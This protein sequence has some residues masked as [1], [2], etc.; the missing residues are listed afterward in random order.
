MR[1][2]DQRLCLVIWLM[3][4]CIVAFSQNKFINEIFK[5]VPSG[6]D[7]KSGTN[8]LFYFKPENGHVYNHIRLELMNNNLDRTE[9]YIRLTY[10]D[11]VYSFNYFIKP[12]TAFMTI[13]AV[14]DSSSTKRRI[15]YEPIVIHDDKG[16]PSFASTA[17]LLSFYFVEQQNVDTVYKKVSKIYPNNMTLLQVKWIA[18]QLQG[19]TSTIKQELIQLEKTKS[20]D[21]KFYLT[22]AYG[23]FATNNVKKGAL[24]FEKYLSSATQPKE[25]NRHLHQLSNFTYDI[26]PVGDSLIRE[27]FKKAALKFPNSELAEVYLVGKL[28]DE[29]IQVF[30]RP[31]LMKNNA[32][33]NVATYESNKYKMELENILEKR[34]EH[35][36]DNF[37][38]AIYYQ[39]YK[40]EHQK[41]FEAAKSYIQTHDSTNFLISKFDVERSPRLKQMYEIVSAYLVASGDYANAKNYIL[42]GLKH[43]NNMYGFGKNSNLYILQAKCLKGLGDNIGEEKALMDAI[44]TNGLPDVYSYLKE[45]YGREKAISFTKKYFEEASNYAMKVDSLAFRTKGGKVYNADDKIIVFSYWWFSCSPCLEEIPLLNSLKASHKQENI[46]WV[47]N[48]E[49]EENLKKMKVK[50]DNWDFISLDR[51]QKSISIYAAPQTYIIDQNRKIRYHHIGKIDQEEAKKFNAVLELLID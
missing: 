33:I 12:E 2:F 44:N 46:K 50:W 21:P 11:S 24:A 43:D 49:S 38:K 22:K 4:N 19:K 37:I 26:S 32:K 10:K 39:Y 41:A 14:P 17:K 35:G 9:E 31:S 27:L 29:Q 7:L 51:N 18:N 20:K 6:T 28:T 25:V 1:N 16:K 45:S 15:I 47:A 3:I 30:N 13:L 36:P 8:A 40:K 5:S 48:N 42:R 34:Q 23:N